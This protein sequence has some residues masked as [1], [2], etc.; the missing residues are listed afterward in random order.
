MGDWSD[1]LDT[2]IR[3]LGIAVRAAIE[4]GCRAELVQATTPLPKLLAAVA[5]LEPELAGMVD[6]ILRLLLNE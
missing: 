2:G 6:Y 5:D 4:T 3:L 1:L